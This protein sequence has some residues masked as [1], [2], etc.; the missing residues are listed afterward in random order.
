METLS[1]AAGVHALIFDCDGT[2]ADSLPLHFEV[3]Q[4]SFEELGLQCP[5]EFL[6]EMSGVPTLQTVVLYNERFGTQVDPH[7]FARDKEARATRRL[8]GVQGFS[9]TVELARVHHGKLPMAVVSG[10]IREHVTTTLAAL[11]I[12]ELFETL[13]TASDPFAP[14]PAPDLFLEAARR[15]GT[16]P[17]RCQVF[18]DADKGLQAARAAGM[19]ATDVRPFLQNP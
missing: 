3:W 15:L 5:L 9:E 18:E 10:G 8:H 11:G 6:Y 14:K 19:V 12:Q 16:A 2:L 4:E 13:L 1:V 17:E 7:S